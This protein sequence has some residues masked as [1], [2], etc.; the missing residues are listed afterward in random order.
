LIRKQIFFQIRTTAKAESV[1]EKSL[2]AR[3]MFKGGSWVLKVCS[4]VY[5]LIVD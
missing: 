4:Q 2:E 1:E 5:L 3:I